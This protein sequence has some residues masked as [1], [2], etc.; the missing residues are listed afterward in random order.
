MWIARGPFGPGV[1]TKD[2]SQHVHIVMKT[3]KEYELGRKKE[4]PLFLDSK[5]VS[6][7]HCMIKVGPF[8]EEDMANPDIHPKLEVHHRSSKAMGVSISP[9]E[10]HQLGEGATF[11]LKEGYAIKV[12]NAI[13]VTFLWT[14]VCC[15]IPTSRN[16]TVPTA[17]CL[18][19]GIHLTH[20]LHSGVTHHIAPVCSPTVPLAASLVGGCNIVKIEWLQELIRVSESEDPNDRFTELPQLSKY[21]PNFSP[22]LEARH[23][24]FEVWETSDHRQTIFSSLR[25]L[26]VGEKN[27]EIDSHMRFLIQRGEGSIE[28]FNVMDAARKMKW[29]RA[30]S[31]GK[32]KESKSLVVLGEEQNIIAAIGEDGW[33]ELADETRTFGLSFKST[34]DVVLSVLD[35]D[36][37]NLIA[38]ANGIDVH[39][40]NRSSSPLP[41]VIPN[42][43]PEEETHPPQSPASTRKRPARRGTRHA[44]EPKALEENMSQ[45][46]EDPGLEAPKRLR[47][48]RQIGRQPSQPPA[49]ETTAA[50][51]RKPEPQSVVPATEP[52]RPRKILTK[53]LDPATGEPAV[54]GL[55]DN[56]LI[57]QATPTSSITQPTI[58]VVVDYT[59]PGRQRSSRLKRRIGATDLGS[60]E[61][62]AAPEGERVTKK[63]RSL[64]EES[65]PTKDTTT[66]LSEMMSAAAQETQQSQTMHST[67]FKS[68]T[69]ATTLGV[70]P[71]EAEISETQGTGSSLVL[72]GNKR[73]AT[74]D[75][76]EMEGIAEAL[77][78]TASS[79]RMGSV[80]PR[81]KRQA[82]EGVNSVEFFEQNSPVTT[83][84]PSANKPAS[85]S[86]IAPARD[87]PTSTGAEPGKPDT[88]DAF[89]KAVASTKRGKR[90]E[91][92]F[93]REFNKLKISKPELEREDLEDKQW[94][95]LEEFGDD[96]NI[97]GN[98]MVI[99]QFDASRTR[100]RGDA[101]ESNPEWNGKPNFKKFKRKN[102]LPSIATRPRRVELVLNEQSGYGVGPSYWKEEDTSQLQDFE[103]SRNVVKDNRMSTQPLVV[104]DSESEEEHSNHRIKGEMA[105]PTIAT[106][107]GRKE[108]KKQPLFLEVSEDD[109]GEETLD[110]S[111][112]LDMTLD[113]A[114][115]PTNK[116]A[117]R[118]KKKA[119]PII[120]DDDSDDDAM[121]KGFQTKGRRR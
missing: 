31:R 114:P 32:A 101:Q 19:L 9:E 119:Q 105:K 95:I 29:H 52:R 59:A 51:G 28:I 4:H 16:T 121:F 120:V 30:L 54:T 12:T 3:D 83:K 113:S 26:C 66:S 49:T 99:V 44:P 70:V 85:T 1:A 88:D 96:L 100:A 20:V 116:M 48:T 50:P 39:D 18:K 27:R 67:R 71:E 72:S 43:I 11:E 40:G 37:S 53:H 65:D 63:Y 111:E 89:L 46:A 86:K 118:V 112:A 82:I 56:S 79:S 115:P 73:K 36:I 2:S 21:R 8:N 107:K 15:Y 34:N 78:P 5:K 102:A 93:D 7:N 77:A 80:A 6:N 109:Q 69:Q 38:P 55:G 68:V 61:S 41:D 76:E 84:L 13:P 45:Q 57:D 75:D 23:K 94:A 106:K 104:N 58:P 103:E 25:F 98:F 74:S 90:A 14:P 97:R 24:R 17:A 108:A 47:P 42:T 64:F 10:S 60:R 33:K 92:E 35:N 110:P 117:R 22:A 91:D 62:S 81:S 87:T